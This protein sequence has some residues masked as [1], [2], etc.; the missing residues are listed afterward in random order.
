[1]SVPNVNLFLN[2][3]ESLAGKDVEFIK[4]NIVK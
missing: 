2:Y 4:N 1:M 3:V